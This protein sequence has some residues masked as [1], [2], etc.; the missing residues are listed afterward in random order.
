MSDIKNISSTFVIVGPEFDADLVDVS[1][2]L[3]S[4]IDERFGDFSGSSLISSFSFD[5]DW[6]TWEM[7]PK[8]DEFVMLVAGE[9]EMILA[10]PEGDTS[11]RL[12]EPGSF[13]IVPK[14]TWHTAKIRTSTQMLFVTPGQ[15]TENRE[16]PRRHG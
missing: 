8:G 14:G 2:D 7:H 15:G 5:S 6:P 9:A 1:D 4:E 11:V 13:V 3:W 12:I 10:L 16:E